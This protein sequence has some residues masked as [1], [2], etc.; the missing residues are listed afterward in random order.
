MADRDQIER[1]LLTAIAA[2]AGAFEA[3]LDA[4]LEAGSFRDVVHRRAFEVIEEVYSDTLATP[5]LDYLRERGVIL[6]P[7]A[8]QD[9]PALLVRRLRDRNVRDDLEALAT[10]VTRQLHDPL[11]ALSEATSA[12]SKIEDLVRDKGAVEESHVAWTER[13]RD[14]DELLALTGILP[15]IPYAFPALTQLLLPMIRGLYVVYGRKKSYK[16]VFSLYNALCAAQQGHNVAVGSG[17]L[18]PD[19]MRTTMLSMH[20]KVDLTRLMAKQLQPE[21]KRRLYTAYPSYTELPVWMPASRI[22]KGVKAL[23]TFARKARAYGAELTI[24]DGAHRLADTR[25]WEEVADYSDRVLDLA[26]DSGT[27]WIAVCQANRSSKKWL[28]GNAAADVTDSDIDMGGNVAWV[29][30]ARNVFRMRKTGHGRVLCDITDNR[31]GAAGMSFA[32]AFDVGTSMMLTTE[33][34]QTELPYGDEQ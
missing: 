28:T 1:A 16:T 17:E 31:Y 27:P 30:H 26:N 20:A 10:Q 15:G 13:F 11:D 2:G 23:Q 22:N 29:Q 34:T 3:T 18:F 6:T 25:N 12:L 4:G 7:A 8:S 9:A 32:F 5:G 33:P 19:E 21:E 24:L 14:E